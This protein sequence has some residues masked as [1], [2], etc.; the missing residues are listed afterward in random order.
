M[1]IVLA[2]LVR[3]K[4]SKVAL[5]FNSDPIDIFE[6]CVWYSEIVRQREIGQQVSELLYCTNF[7]QSPTVTARAQSYEIEQNSLLTICSYCF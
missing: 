6:T 5:S 1:S 3:M 2:L 4:S 7:D